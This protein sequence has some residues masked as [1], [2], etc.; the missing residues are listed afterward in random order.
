MLCGACID[1][2]GLPEV[3]ISIIIIRTQHSILCIAASLDELM[4]ETLSS[5]SLV[6]N[7]VMSVVSLTAACTTHR[8]V[9]WGNIA[10]I[11]IY[12]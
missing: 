1:I 11:I 4:T 2:G 3:D 12:H 10:T 5:L 8:M 6:L 9:Q 7:I